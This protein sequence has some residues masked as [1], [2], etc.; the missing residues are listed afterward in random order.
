LYSD[1]NKVVSV[2]EIKPSS[3]L[4]ITPNNYIYNKLI[5]KVFCVAQLNDQGLLTSVDVLLNRPLMPWQLRYF[6]QNILKQSG[7]SWESLVAP[8]REYI[9][10]N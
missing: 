2:S 7:L 1:N 3:H 4:F 10:T 9:T 8:L 5:T 6:Q